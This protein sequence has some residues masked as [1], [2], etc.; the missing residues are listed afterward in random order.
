MKLVDLSQNSEPIW[1]STQWPPGIGHRS[2]SFQW[3]HNGHDGVSNHQR[4]ECLLNRLFRRRSKK[5]S[6]L[7]VNS[8][9]GGNSPLT[10]EFSAQMANNAENA[11]IWWR[12]HVFPQFVM[13]K[14]YEDNKQC[15]VEK[16]LDTIHQFCKLILLFIYC[17]E[18]V[19]THSGSWLANRHYQSASISSFY[20]RSVYFYRQV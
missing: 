12:H 16:Y 14:L 20:R 17:G 11:S 18:T 3:R 2:M 5:T 7:R 1:W 4:P 9:C 8:L 15:Y 19:F 6:K 13:K 10:D